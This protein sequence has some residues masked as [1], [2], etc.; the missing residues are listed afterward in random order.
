MTEYVSL[1]LLPLFVLLALLCL[2]PGQRAMAADVAAPEVS[3]VATDVQASAEAVMQQFAGDYEEAPERRIEAK[4]KHEIL[5]FM[6][7]SLLILLFLTGSL[8]VAMVVFDKDVFV[9]HLICAGLSLTLAAVHAATSI[10][11]FWPF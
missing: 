5:F 11:W 10:A 2:L 7:I 8:G 4:R 1:R 9:A 6:G 3:G